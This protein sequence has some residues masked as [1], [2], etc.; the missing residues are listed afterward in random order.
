MKKGVLYGITHDRETGAP[1]IRESRVLKV[2]IGIPKGRAISIYKWKGKWVIRYGAWE[3]KNGKKSLVMKT[4]AQ[5]ATR[6]EAE[7]FHAAHFKEAA[8]SNR[9]QKIP[10]F[11]FNKR[12]IVE[13]GNKPV[14]VF[15]PDFAAIDAHGEMPREIDI[16][17]MSESPYQCEYQMWSASELKCHGDGM[18]AERSV[19]MVTKENS[20]LF[21]LWKAAKDSGQKF[22]DCKPCWLD[23]C[24]YAQDGGGCKPG[25][26]ISFQLANNMRLGATAYFH[27]TGFRS[28]SQI[29]SAIESVRH[30]ATRMGSSIVGLPLKMVLAPFRTNHNGQAATQYGVSL[31]L[32]AEDMAALR[33][34][35]QESAWVPHQIQ[36]QRTV[37]MEMAP[38]LS[39][40]WVAA[41]FY[42]EAADIT[43]DFE[44]ETG[45]DVEVGQGSQQAKAAT[46]QK[47]EQLREDIARRR[48]A[49]TPAETAPAP[50][51]TSPGTLYR[52][53]SPRMPMEPPP[54]VTLPGTARPPMPSTENIKAREDI[55]REFLPVLGGTRF[56]AILKR[57]TGVES[58][59]GVVKGNVVAVFNAMTEGVGQMRQEKKDAGVVAGV[60]AGGDRAPAAVVVD[61]TPADIAREVGGEA[62]DAGFQL[63]PE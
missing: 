21:P 23:G 18:D 3:E 48:A 12:S 55:Q 41:E 39:A 46:E 17:L 44:E 36:A 35:F 63:L 8:T 61:R 2:G 60:V 52:S 57:V 49:E 59:E 5:V 62:G 22:Y 58:T 24:E 28:S 34:R 43:L 14:E 31:E 54:A 30:S 19:S 15:E 40:P 56:R 37:E 33:A 51:E 53:S 32:R 27:T 38:Q 11:T 29:F 47:T 25:M 6:Q 13:E 20:P 42:P 4:A 1:I 10:F 7:A 16:V 26:T 9:P 45:G 50:A